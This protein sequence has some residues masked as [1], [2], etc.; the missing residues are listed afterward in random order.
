MKD[1]E[2]DA[3]QLAVVMDV[4][5]ALEKA[6]WTE[7]LGNPKRR[8]WRQQLANEI[9]QKNRW[10]VAK[11]ITRFRIW[12]LTQA[13]L[14]EALGVTERHLRDLEEKGLPH[15]GSGP[16]LRYPWPDVF[17]WYCCYQGRVV[18]RRDK[19]EPVPFLDPAIARA[20]YFE[21]RAREEARWAAQGR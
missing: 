18:V 4:A 19:T 3:L 15:E 2:Y 1:T 16:R 12:L 13:Q 5:T 14:S 17:H 10:A 20:E 11:P 7:D 21:G 6:H 9:A 8:K